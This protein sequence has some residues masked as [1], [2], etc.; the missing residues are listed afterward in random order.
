[1]LTIVEGRFS[2]ATEFHDPGLVNAAGFPVE[3]AS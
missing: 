1:V 3:P 2:R